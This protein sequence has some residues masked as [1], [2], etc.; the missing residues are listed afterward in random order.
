MFNIQ[1]SIRIEQNTY[2]A[3]ME[4][5]TVETN[6]IKENSLLEICIY[7]SETYLISLVDYN[8]FTN[9]ISKDNG[10]M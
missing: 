2:L 5:D 3:N 10:K 6:Q 1:T 8:D 7:V 4:I 9:I